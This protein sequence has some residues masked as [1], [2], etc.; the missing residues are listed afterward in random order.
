MTPLFEALSRR[1]LPWLEPKF[2]QLEAAHRAGTL[3]HAWLISGPAGVGKINLALALAARLLGDD[4]RHGELDPATALAAMAAR[5][6]PVDRYADLHW[7]HP[8]EDKETI[9]IDQVREV[10][11]AFALTAHRGAGKVI[12]IE[13]AEALTTAAANALLKTLEEPT[14]QG[15][16]LLVSHQPGRLPA[17]VRSRCQH[18]VLRAPAADVVTKWLSVSPDVVAAAQRWVGSAPLR[19]AAAI[20]EDKGTIFNKLESDLIEVSHDKADPQIV[21]QAW[22]K[23]DTEVALNW[24]RRRLHE[25]L[26]ARLASPRGSTEVTVPAAATLHNVWRALPARTLFDEYER[27]EKLL[28]AQGSGLNVELALVA[29]LNAFIVNR[30]RS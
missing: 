4:A 26:R 27:A 21:A 6:E 9:S 16:L 24:L 7:L 1:L 28:N 8:L 14:P 2:A 15:Y 23:G 18:L 22:A 30:G 3:G 12:L 5:H 20:S 10:I 25:V 11:E 17:T 19:L 13:P 29:M